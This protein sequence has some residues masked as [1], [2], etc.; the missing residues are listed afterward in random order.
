MVLLAWV[1]GWGAVWL[2]QTPAPIETRE[3]A[4]LWP[5]PDQVWRQVQEWTLKPEQ[6]TW[7]RIHWTDNPE[8]AF[9]EARRTARP[10]FL[11]QASAPYSR[12]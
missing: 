2:C 12:I 8:R 1:F 7:E 4:A 9:L 11:F 6:R 5:D 10:V 3:Q